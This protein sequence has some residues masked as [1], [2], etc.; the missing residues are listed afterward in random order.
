[1][2][3]KGDID[4][5]LIFGRPFKPVALGL[6]LAMLVLVVANIH[7]TGRLGEG[8]LGH[9]I[10][11][12]SGFSL[13]FLMGGWWTRWQVWAEIGLL[14]ACSTYLT[15]GIFLG[16]TDLQDQSMWLSF[17]SALIAGGAF[18]LEVNSDGIGKR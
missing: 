1:M 6:S 9:V 5:W 14:L 16:L 2:V 12:V 17:S 8:W 18:W 4:G 7:G 11:V 13:F 15:R 10:A 3:T